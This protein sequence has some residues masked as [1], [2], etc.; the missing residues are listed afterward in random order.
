MLK[1]ALIL[2]LVSF[3]ILQADELVKPANKTTPSF[4]LKKMF[5][6]E[7]RLKTARAFGWTAFSVAHLTL[8]FWG[9]KI[10]MRKISNFKLFMGDEFQKSYDSALSNNNITAAEKEALRKIKNKYLQQTPLDFASDTICLG[11]IGY[12][13][14]QSLENAYYH[15]QETQR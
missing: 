11:F 12:S 2:S 4:S 3:S 13:L 6:K 8:I 14:K 10:T 1:K 5:A 9:T 15:F 7:N